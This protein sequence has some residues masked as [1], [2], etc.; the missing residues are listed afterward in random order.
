[1]SVGVKTQKQ[2]NL[3]FFFNAMTL[4]ILYIMNKVYGTVAETSDVFS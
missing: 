1:M 3:I 2:F 4:R